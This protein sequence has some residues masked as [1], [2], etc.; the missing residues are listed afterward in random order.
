MRLDR[1]FDAYLRHV[2]I[3][4]GLAA[5]TVA[6]YRRDLGGY[7]QWLGSHG[8]T[9]TAEITATEVTDFIAE[10]ANT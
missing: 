5:H 8:V 2:T 7:V 10:Q 4:R 3:E 1:A 6:A 9:E